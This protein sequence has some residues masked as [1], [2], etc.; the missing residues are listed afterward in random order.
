MKTSQHKKGHAAEKLSQLQARIRKLEAEKQELKQ[1]LE[2]LRKFKTISDKA[3]HGVVMRDLEGNFIYVNEAF[4]RMHGYEPEEILGKHFSI[5][6]TPE[7]LE[8]IEKLRRQPGEGYISE[9]GHKKRDGTVFPTLMTGSTIKDEDGNPLYFS[10]TAIDITELKRTEEALRR[11]TLRNKLIL[12]AAM[13][14]FY[15]IDM[16]GKILEAN[17]AASL[18][19]GYSKEELV[20]ANI[21]DFEAR[22]E[23]SKTSQYARKAMKKGFHRFEAKHRNKDGRVM[24]LEFST[25]FIKIGKERFFFSFFRDIT[26]KKK[27]ENALRH[28]EEE[29]E[30]KNLN[31]EEVNTALRVLLE[32]RE[33]DKK[34]LEEKVLSN[35]KELVEPNLERLKRSGLNKKQEA[36][37]S[38][39]ESN[40]KDIISP[41]SRTLTSKYL[42]LSPTEIQVANLVRD[43]RTTKEIADLMNLSART[44][45]FHRANIR[46][47]LGLKNMKA[48]L[49]SYL[50]SIN[51]TGL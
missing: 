2:D 31:L 8:H 45:E 37:A 26:E 14:G 40:L 30:I 49:R 46:T 51:N 48:N 33:Q 28:R 44:V 25:N 39:L 43:G 13:N 38:V 29:L 10:A 41:F 17:R 6:H 11:Q 42:S 7:Q 27:T 23:G 9:V 34:E 16:S 12:E 5:V 35:V 20:G 18:I 1:K 4:A 22:K 21:L 50:L 3:G 36:Y 32:K 24:D 19:T 15:I 47:K